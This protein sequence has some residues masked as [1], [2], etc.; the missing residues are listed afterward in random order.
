MLESWKTILSADATL[1]LDQL[2]THPSRHHR[3]RSSE[4]PVEVINAY[5]ILGCSSGS[6]YLGVGT[7]FQFHR[8]RNAVFDLILRTM[9]SERPTLPAQRGHR[10]ALG[11]LIA[12]FFREDSTYPAIVWATPAWV[13]IHNA[14]DT[15]AIRRKD[16]ARSAHLVGKTTRD[17]ASLEVLH[18]STINLSVPR[19]KLCFYYPKRVSS[20]LVTRRTRTI[21]TPD[22]TCWHGP[23]TGL[24]LGGRAEICDAQAG[25]FTGNEP[26]LHFDSCSGHEYLAAPAVTFARIV[27]LSPIA[28]SRSPYAETNFQLQQIAVVSF[29]RFTFHPESMRV[30]VLL[31][32]DRI[33]ERFLFEHVGL[34]DALAELL[35]VPR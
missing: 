9:G 28:P 16:V 19:R 22:G 10:E 33:F 3:L 17:P 31:A 6:T 5:K 25:V 14:L 27:P 23:E 29:L 35:G 20:L 24:S 30:M 18:G 7:E 34:A 4:P 12:Q 13:R 26:F 11:D 21:W 32:A 2:L 15:H 8:H 1:L